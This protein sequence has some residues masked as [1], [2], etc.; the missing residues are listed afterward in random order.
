[1]KTFLNY[2]ETIFSFIY[3]SLLIPA[4]AIITPVFS[5]SKRRNYNAPGGVKVQRPDP[6]K[7][8]RK[9]RP[10]E[11]QYYKPQPPIS[12]T[13]FPKLNIKNDFKFNFKPD[14]RFKNP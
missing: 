8:L 2:R 12:T 13:S 9:P 3:I 10:E 5:A 14:S 11:L 4:G 7:G 6:V 1:M